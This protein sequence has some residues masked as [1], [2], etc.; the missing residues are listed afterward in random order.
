M[1]A[2]AA[3]LVFGVL[4]VSPFLWGGK[5]E[6][7]VRPPQKLSPCAEL[8]LEIEQMGPVDITAWPQERILLGL[9]CAHQGDPGPEPP[10]VGVAVPGS[11][12]IPFDMSYRNPG[13][14]D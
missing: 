10:T 14:F 5:A 7:Q 12:V 2:I 11:P 3:I 6:A 9:F 1:R 8:R 13:S 4:G